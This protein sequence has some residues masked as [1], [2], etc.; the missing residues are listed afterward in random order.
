LLLKGDSLFLFMLVVFNALI[1]KHLLLNESLEYKFM[2][3]IYILRRK[4]P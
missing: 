2:T 1:I 4:P 3:S